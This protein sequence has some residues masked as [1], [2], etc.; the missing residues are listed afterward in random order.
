M[1]LVL[2][3]L[4]GSAHPLARAVVGA[5]QAKGIATPPAEGFV[6]RTGFGVA[7][8]VRSWQTGCYAQGT[9]WEV[10]GRERCAC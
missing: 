7:G 4:P 10:D 6:S 1:M 3:T 9:H 8:T 5:A 2:R